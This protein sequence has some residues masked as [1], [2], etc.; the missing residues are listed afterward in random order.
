MTGLMSDKPWELSSGRLRGIK[1]MTSEFEWDILTSSIRTQNQ[2]C[3]I[4]PSSNCIDQL[5]NPVAVA[6]GMWPFRSRFMELNREIL[7]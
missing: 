3:W 7:I 2:N 5:I 6:V 1:G 4:S